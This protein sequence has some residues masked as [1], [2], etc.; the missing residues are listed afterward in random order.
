MNTLLVNESYKEWWK[1]NINETFF[2]YTLQHVIN[3]KFIIKLPQY[4]SFTSLLSFTTTYREH[5]NNE[6][7]MY[8]DNYE[9]KMIVYDIMLSNYDNTSYT[10]Y[11]TICKFLTDD[12]N[13]FGKRNHFHFKD[14]I[15]NIFMN[16][17]N[18]SQNVYFAMIKFIKICKIKYC[19]SYNNE[20]LCMDKIINPCYI[21]HMNKLYLFSKTDIICLFYNSLISSNHEFHSSP[22]FIKNPYINIKF[23]YSMLAQLYFHYKYNSISYNNVIEAFFKSNFNLKEFISN[24]DTMITE[25]NIKRFLDNYNTN[26]NAIIKFLKQMIK[27]TNE[28]IVKKSAQLSYCKL[29]PEKI[30]YQAYKPYLLHY[31]LFRFCSDQSKSHDSYN[32]FKKKIIRFNKYSPKFGRSILHLPNNKSSR[33]KLNFKSKIPNEKY[34]TYETKYIN[35]YNNNYTEESVEPVLASGL[36][37]RKKQ[38]EQ[39]EYDDDSSSVSDTDEEE[40]FNSQNQEI[41]DIIQRIIETDFATRNRF[42][43]N[44]PVRF[45][46]NISENLQIDQTY[47]NIDIDQN[48]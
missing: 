11:E 24:N 42:I 48:D 25:L 44:I 35:Y 4:E 34:F 7:K 30:Y 1:D 33:L 14:N 40:Y 28:N 38:E 21:F 29:F 43:N 37:K 41:G 5:L 19:K 22:K 39:Q 47:Q 2:K 20:D 13:T 17:I 31:L 23:T 6:I 9:A 8:S 16:Y 3:N 10:K 15:V 46:D 12:Y 36:L 32:I 45:N 18:K 27:Y 26:M